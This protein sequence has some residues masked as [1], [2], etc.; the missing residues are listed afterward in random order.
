L[1]CKKRQGNHDFGSH[2]QPAFGS[3]TRNTQSPIK[4]PGKQDPSSPSI[5]KQKEV[6]GL[7]KTNRTMYDT[8]GRGGIRRGGGR[9][10]GGGWWGGCGGGGGG[11]G[12]LVGGGGGVGGWIDAD[13]RLETNSA[14]R[15]LRRAGGMMKG[16]DWKSQKG[17]QW[18]VEGFSRRGY[19]RKTKGGEAFKSPYKRKER[20]GRRHRHRLKKGSGRR[21]SEGRGGGERMQKMFS[22]S[23]FRTKK[24][25]L[26]LAGTGGLA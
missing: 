13:E 9:G 26:E 6:R 8:E 15:E 16:K 22:S 14:S 5:L 20:Q 24:E 1:L 21:S 12:V 17:E 4:W 25:V 11:G 18:R 2:A 10:G 19:N 23:N 7:W 3:F